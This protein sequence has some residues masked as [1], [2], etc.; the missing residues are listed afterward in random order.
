MKKLIVILLLWI[1]PV[2]GESFG[3]GNEWASKF[4]IDDGY[5]G[6]VISAP[7]NGTVDSFLCYCEVE[8]FGSNHDCAVFMYI[9][10]DND[11]A[12]YFAKSEQR[13]IGDAGNVNWQKFNPSGTIT[14]T[15]GTN[16]IVGLAADEAGGVM[17]QRYGDPATGDT[18]GY[19]YSQLD[20]YDYNSPTDPLRTT[21][22]LANYAASLKIYYTPE[23]E[24]ESIL[25]R[26]RRIDK[27]EQR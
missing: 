26:R 8:V 23:G 5:C 11:S 12:D 7:D 9:V 4:T 1:S 6:T 15:E 10:Y 13:N 19:K 16:Y 2:F 18:L 17:N 24:D 25:L 22:R 3:W 14:L 27:G 20:W 21:G